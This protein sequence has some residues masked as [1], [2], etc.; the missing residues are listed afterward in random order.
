MR[1]RLPALMLA[2]FLFAGCAG[3]HTVL[4]NPLATPTLSFAPEQTPDEPD[5]FIRFHS[6][7]PEQIDLGIEELRVQASAAG[8]AVEKL[9]FP[10]S[11]PTGQARLEMWSG[12]NEDNVQVLIEV[13][14]DNIA[15]YLSEIGQPT[16][17]SSASGQ[18]N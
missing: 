17:Q 14:Y 2:G 11:V 18:I 12:V 8:F 1:H 3:E 9:D 10:L 4:D 16:D 7:P 13:G 5:G 6:L 15:M